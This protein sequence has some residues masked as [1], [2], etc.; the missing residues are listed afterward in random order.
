MI[1]TNQSTSLSV[2]IRYTIY[3]GR[4]FLHTCI[5]I[6]HF[7]RSQVEDIEWVS[8]Y[9]ALQIR[10]IT[11]SPTLHTLMLA[12][13][14]KLGAPDFYLHSGVHFSSGVIFKLIS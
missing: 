4:I 3:A 14:V 11:V 1:S 12:G 8:S 7:N 6:V 2:S 13:S 5:N 9:S 10:K